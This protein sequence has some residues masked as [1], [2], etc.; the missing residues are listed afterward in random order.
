MRE[1]ARLDQ[2][3]DAA[4]CWLLISLK[5]FRQ[6]AARWASGGSSRFSSSFRNGVAKVPMFEVEADWVE[7]TLRDIPT[8]SLSPCLDLGSSDLSYRAEFQPWIDERVFRPLAAR[9]VVITYCDLK[10]APGVDLVIDLMCDDDHAQI[11][12]LDPKLVLCCNILEHVAEPAAFAARLA[13]VVRPGGRIVLTVPHRFPYHEDPIDNGFR[14]TT[15]EVAALFPGFAVEQASILQAGSYR[16]DVARRPV[17]ILARH[18]IR[19]S[20]PFLSLKKWKISAE[21][22]LYLF[23]PYEVTCLLLLKTE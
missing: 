15:L 23:R 14:P 10:N 12:A 21:K 9:G 1:Y 6:W 22:L 17:G 16:D 8:A 13:T 20:L 2:S 19:L 7:N 18:L 5:T 3:S 4:L 11:V